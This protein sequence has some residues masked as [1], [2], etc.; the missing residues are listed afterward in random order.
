MYVSVSV[1][2]QVFHCM[3]VCLQGDALPPPWI[4]GL[5]VFTRG[6]GRG[7]SKIIS[8]SVSPMSV[9]GGPWMVWFVITY[10]KRRI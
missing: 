3:P 9:G 10:L 2:A 6:N 4:R 7:L 1:E 8:P 5:G